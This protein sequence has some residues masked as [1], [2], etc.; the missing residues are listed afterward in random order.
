MHP[1]NWTPVPVFVVLALLAPR[2]SAAPEVR[3]DWNDI[4]CADTPLDASPGATLG[5]F[6][7]G[8]DQPQQA[9]E[10]HFRC[11]RTGPA[12]VPD[13]WRF[14]AAGCAHDRLAI[15][16][17]VP[18]A[19][20]SCPALPGSGLATA[21]RAVTYDE[22]AGRERIA[23]RLDY[24]GVSSS[25]DPT[26][27]RILAWLVMD[28]GGFVAGP[29]DPPATCG[30]LDE[31]VCFALESAT[32]TDLSGAVHSWPITTPFASIN[33]AALGGPAACAATPA[34]P[35]TWGA[36]KRQYR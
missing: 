26:A 21:L 5:A 20:K 1:R 16:W 34:Q 36:V 35:A 3:L 14:D 13:A 19:V 17:L 2:A 12:G 24:P 11:G 4:L 9:Y 10:L 23:F 32:W 33:A 8:Q 25:T 18:A 28:L 7:I 27:R 31:A 15:E 22:G 29:G 30:G 6:V